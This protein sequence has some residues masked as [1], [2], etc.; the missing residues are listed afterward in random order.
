[1]D[2]MGGLAK[3]MPRAALLCL[4]GSVAICGIPPLNGFVSEFLLYFGFFSQLQ[5]D[6]LVYLV[7]LAPLLALVGGLAVVAFTKLYSSVFL[8]SPRSP[9][10]AH[11]HEAGVTMLL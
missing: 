9:G 7:L 4:V 1:M 5:S 8:G 10:A 3:G 6:S 11:S 2:L